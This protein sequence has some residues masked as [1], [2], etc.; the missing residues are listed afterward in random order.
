ME[1]I[2]LA[3]LL[4]ILSRPRA[5]AGGR[6]IQRRVREGAAFFTQRE[7]LYGFF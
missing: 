5:P 4:A 2:A 7:V 3:I 6:V 1:A